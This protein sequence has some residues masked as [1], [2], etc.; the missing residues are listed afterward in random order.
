MAGIVL[1]NEIMSLPASSAA[2][3]KSATR[4]TFGLSLV[5]SGIVV[6]FRTALM[7]LFMLSVFVPKE[8][9]PSLMLGQDTLISSA[10]IPSFSCSNR[11]ATY[12]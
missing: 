8:M 9:P 11:S 6:A 5:I 3:A 7:T 4:V 12:A 1:I 10:A 2:L